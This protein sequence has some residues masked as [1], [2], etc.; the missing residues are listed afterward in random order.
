M[1]EIPKAYSAKDHEDR[2]YKMWEQSGAFAPDPNPKKEPYSIMMPP[3]NATGT[4]H[5]G[6]AT[7]LAI[8]DILIRFKRMQGFSTLYLPG[9][10]HA[11][12]ATQSVVEKKLQSEG[13]KNPRE[14]LGREKL[15]QEIRK[16]VDVSK[17]TIRKQIRK[18]GTSCDWSRERYTF[19]D[20]MNVAVN[21]L[22]RMMYED[23]LIY[24]GGRIVN[25]D[26]KMQTTVADD[27][28]EY[29]EEKAPFYYFKYGPVVIGTAR[30]ETKF[31]DKVIVVHPKDK[32]YKHLIGQEF[33]VEWIEG[34]IRAK[35]IADECI[36]RELGTGA[37]TITP[38]HSVIDFELAQKYNL[39]HPQIIDFNGKILPEWSKSCGGLDL[40]TA[41]EK[42]VE[43]LEKKGLVDHIDE[44]YVHNVSVNYRGKGIVEPQIMKQWFVDVNKPVIL[45]KKKKCSIKEV[46][47]DTVRSKMIHIIPDRFEKD[48]FHWIDNLRDWCISRQIWWGHRI[49]VWYCVGGEACKLEC[50]NPIVSVNSVEK[51]PHC[52]TTKLRQDEDTLDTWFCAKLLKFSTFGG[53]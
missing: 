39:E 2:I 9:T 5:L 37:M 24:R 10:D 21:E 35:V 52:G 26:P 6:H 20:E 34:T 23:G 42:V 18:M 11:A 8:E 16:F 45:W 12:I 53:P 28:L 13:I 31:G 25:W 15:L 3:P 38:A 50:K 14:E 30:P 33:D 43:I 19:S 29:V 22:F 4:L 17:S 44:N 51:C 32:R 1:K 47:Q 7:M 48:Y 46:L 40:L 27:E 49:P 36:D 41:R